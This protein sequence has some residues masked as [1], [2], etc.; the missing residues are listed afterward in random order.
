[1]LHKF[2]KF[3]RKL[4]KVYISVTN[5]EKRSSKQSM[6]IEMMGYE[7]VEKIAMPSG[8]SRIY[9]PR[10]RVGGYPF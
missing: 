8:N 1:V 5:I 4:S 7:V 10:A 9:F 6:K 3:H 2:I